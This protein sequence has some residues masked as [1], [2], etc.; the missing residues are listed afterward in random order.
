MI[1]LLINGGIA[2]VTS[3]VTW[4]LARRKYNVEVDGNE[5]NNIQKQLDKDITKEERDIIRAEI[6]REYFANLEG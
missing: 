3:I 4:I 2:I 5:L 6:I 1:D